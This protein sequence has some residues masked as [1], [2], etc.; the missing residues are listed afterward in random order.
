MIEAG[1]RKSINIFSFKSSNICLTKLVSSLKL[2]DSKKVNFLLIFP[3]TA[4]PNL[5]ADSIADWLMLGS[6]PGNPIEVG[7][8]KVLGVW[9]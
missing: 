7:Q 1:Y 4:L 8:V 2:N 5:I 9:S 3:L 6:A